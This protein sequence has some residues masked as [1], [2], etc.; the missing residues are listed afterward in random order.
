MRKKKWQI[1]RTGILGEAGSGEDQ[2]RSEQGKAVGIGGTFN[3]R[4]IGTYINTQVSERANCHLAKSWDLGKQNM[5][6]VNLNGW[7]GT[8]RKHWLPPSRVSLDGIILEDWARP[9]WK[10]WR[11]RSA[12]SWPFQSLGKHCQSIL[13]RLLPTLL[14]TNLPWRPPL[15]LVN[16]SDMPT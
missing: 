3:D 1:Q 13:G 12:R 10:D 7:K 9:A 11:E 6:Q 4:G 15:C 8:K 16:L 2:S 14:P 5:G